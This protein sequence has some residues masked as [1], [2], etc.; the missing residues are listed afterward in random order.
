MKSKQSRAA[1]QPAARIPT[2]PA[3]LDHSQ[4]QS[5]SCVSSASTRQ[6]RNDWGSRAR[7]GAQP[8]SIA[9]AHYKGA[10]V[11]TLGDHILLPA[12]SPGASLTPTLCSHRVPRQ[13]CPVPVHT[14][15]QVVPSSPSAAPG[16]SVPGTL[17]ATGPG[18]VSSSR[19]RGSHGSERPHY[20]SRPLSREGRAR[21]QSWHC[22][23]GLP[24]AQEWALWTWEP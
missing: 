14:S 20:V 7:S 6:A 12:S 10:A 5:A 8:D 9:T 11:R 4:G 21:H 3:G 17:Q 18:L 1:Q 19:L 22:P 15:T 16:T 13:M 23:P 24:A 2:V